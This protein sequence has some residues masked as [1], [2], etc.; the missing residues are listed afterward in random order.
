MF[1]FEILRIIYIINIYFNKLFFCDLSEKKIKET[2]DEKNLYR[3]E[4]EEKKNSS[5]AATT[6]T[7][8]R[9]KF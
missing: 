6:V 5:T 9:R 1:Y 2:F 4:I 8:T 3:R 7:K